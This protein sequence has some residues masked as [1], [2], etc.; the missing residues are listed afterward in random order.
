MRW[1]IFMISVCCLN[2]RAEHID[3]PWGCYSSMLTE[4][5]V[6]HSELRGGLVRAS[7]AQLEPEPGA[8]DFSAIDQQ[9]RI[10]PEG[11][12]WSLAVY[13][14]W[15]S[16]ETAIAAESKGPLNRPQRSKRPMKPHTPQWMVSEMHIE[17]FNCS[18]RGQMTTMPKYWDPV[19]QKRLEILMQALAEKYK[20]DERLKLVYVPQMTGNGIEGHFNGVS[21][22][23]LLAAAGIAAGEEDKFAMIWT[24]AALSAIRSTARAFDNKA[25]AFEVHELL[26]SSEIPEKIMGEIITDPALKNQV[27][28][29]MWW[30]SGK[31]SYQPDLL[32]AIEKFP[33]DLYGQVIGRS[34]Q[35]HRFPD[36]NYS[37]VFRQAE[38]LG[39]RYIEAWNYEFEHHTH[40]PLFEEFNRHCRKRYAGTTSGR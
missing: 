30:I 14:G 35:P 38:R 28:I 3:K 34:D 25:V 27:G 21:Q 36:G 16:V 8:F 31:S 17:T 32:Q 40:D 6:K 22:S 19:V 12:S 15:T 1:I 2:G 10:L 13:A 5:A 29:G 23:T 33:G 37:A 4:R 24:D 20:T 9:L 18:F 7:W 26:G 39:M 11:K